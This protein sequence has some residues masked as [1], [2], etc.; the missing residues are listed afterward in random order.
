[1]GRSL[2]RQTVAIHGSRSG[3][4]RKSLRTKYCCKGGCGGRAGSGQRPQ[5]S[6]LLWQPSLPGMR[7]SA[8]TLYQAGL[9]G[10]IFP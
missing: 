8:P 9:G 10:A 3:Q 2:E 7:D 6:P 4:H 1:M 5:Q